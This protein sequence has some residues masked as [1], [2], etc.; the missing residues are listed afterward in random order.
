MV[1]MPN[2]DLFLSALRR[3]Y[4]PDERVQIRGVDWA[5]YE[6]LLALRG[7]QRRPRVT[8]LDGAVELMSIS[9]HHERTRFVLGRLLEIYL[10]E[11][12]VPFC[13]YGQTTYKA[14]RASVGF[15]ADECYVLGVPR[16]DRPDLVVEVVWT[17]GAADKLPI[18]QA[19]GVPEVWIWQGGEL[20]A[21]VLRSGGYQA[22]SRSELLP[23]LDLAFLASFVARTERI[24]S[25][26]L[27][28]FRDAV[29]GGAP[30]S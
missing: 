20:R 8:Y 27:L 6:A 5:G 16:D 21:F 26:T 30:R 9:K 12:G 15:E 22:D 7:E 1:A 25:D 29:L 24:D 11:L 19:F 18:Y 4:L 10:L 14:R 2:E 3:E 17:N 28:A 23:R 13:G